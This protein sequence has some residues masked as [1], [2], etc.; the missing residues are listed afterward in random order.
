MNKSFTEDDLGPEEGWE[1]FFGHGMMKRR[2]FVFGSQDDGRLEV[3]YYRREICENEPGFGVA[4]KSLIGR[5]GLCMGVGIC[6]R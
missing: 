2:S 1:D 4:E 5:I 6:C 3:R